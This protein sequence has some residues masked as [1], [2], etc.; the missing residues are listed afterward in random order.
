[1]DIDAETGQHHFRYYVQTAEL[2]D[3]FWTALGHEVTA[4]KS[5]AVRSALVV[6]LDL[7]ILLWHGIAWDGGRIDRVINPV[8]DAEELEYLQTFLDLRSD[9]DRR[10]SVIHDFGPSIDVCE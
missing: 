6:S 5:E 2:R 1:M 10:D 3:V 8:D 7:G 9:V 4:L